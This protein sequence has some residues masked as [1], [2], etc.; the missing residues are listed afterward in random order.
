MDINTRAAA[1]GAKIAEATDHE[2]YSGPFKG[3]KLRNID[4]NVAPYYLGTYEHEL[5]P[6]IHCIIRNNK[7]KTILNV[8]CSFGYYACG[9]AM[10]MPHSIVVAR[11]IDKT[12]LEAC[13]ETAN[14]N[15][16]K[17]VLFDA[18]ISDK[19]PDLI[20][21]DIEGNEDNYLLPPLHTA[22][23]SFTNSDILVESHECIK[24][25][26]TKLLIDRYSATHDIDIIHNKSALFN[27]DQL[28]PGIYIEHFDHAI[29]TW[30]GRAGQTPWL[31]MAKKC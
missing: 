23:W 11:D 27:L 30:E 24:P 8:G 29:A 14:N 18:N 28:F 7:Y 12:A 13:K 3:L 9:L 10:T 25:G 17:N 15:G 20:I 19:G 16:L 26:I 1:L 21:M 22:A 31:F 5:H 6:Y 2:V 4:G